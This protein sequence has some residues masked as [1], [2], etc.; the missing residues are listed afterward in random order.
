MDFINVSK[1]LRDTES[2]LRRTACYGG[3][4]CY[5][6]KLPKLLR[7]NARVGNMNEFQNII[8]YIHCNEFGG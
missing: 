7:E 8:N 2:L 1:I 5:G 6:A 3:T 4:D